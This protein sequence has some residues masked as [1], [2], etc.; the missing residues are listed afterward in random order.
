MLPRGPGAT[1][2]RSAETR[3]SATDRR[4]VGIQHW[5]PVIFLA[6][7]LAVSG[8]PR[9]ASAGSMDTLTVVTL[10]LWHDSHE[11]PKR[12]PV[13]VAEM[14]RIR[15]DVLCLQEVLQHPSL[16]NQ[17]ETLGDSLGCQVQFASVDGPERPKR[18]GNAI[19]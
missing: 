8:L 19:L 18:Y 12:L 6:L 17:A 16:R 5:V 4:S 3:M 2:S 10:N 15:P 13:I 9:P 1:V 14:R 7:P 11:W